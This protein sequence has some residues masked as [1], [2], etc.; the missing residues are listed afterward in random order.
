MAFAITS[1]AFAEGATVPQQ[2]TCDG[3]DAPPPIKLSNPPQNTRSFAV[4]MDD[5][6]APKGTFTHW[7]AY[8]IPANNAELQSEAGKTL[9]NSFGREGYGGPCPPPGHGPHRYFFTVYAVDVPVLALAGETRQDLE[10]A[11][12]THALARAQLMGKYERS[13]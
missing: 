2:F 6:D 8:D 9:R 13:R 4:I 11:L 12:E 10:K 5:P 7:L 1:P 3:N